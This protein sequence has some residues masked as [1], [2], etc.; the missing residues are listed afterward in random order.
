MYEHQSQWN[1]DNGKEIF[2]SL[3]TDG[4]YQVAERKTIHKRKKSQF[5]QYF[6]TCVDCTRQLAHFLAGGAIAFYV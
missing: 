2:P 4:L 1:T 3:V 5:I 6:T